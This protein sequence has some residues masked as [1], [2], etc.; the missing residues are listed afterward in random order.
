MKPD[1]ANAHYNLAWT[2]YQKADYVRAASELQTAISLIDPQ[3][4]R[5]DFEKAQSQLE[6]FKAKLPKETSTATESAQ[7]TQLTL[8]TPAKPVEPKIK[9]PSEA[10]PEAK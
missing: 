3:K 7:P 9:L 6:T 5:A 4:D 2:S 10:S 1:W 8:P